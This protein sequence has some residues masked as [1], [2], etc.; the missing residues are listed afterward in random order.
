MT[1]P[2]SPIQPAILAEDVEL[3][4]RR[5][6]PGRCDVVIISLSSPVASIHGDLS[7]AQVTELID[8]LLRL[9]AP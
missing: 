8:Q 3:R 6:L 1:D 5:A 4:V 9:I 7:R 2:P